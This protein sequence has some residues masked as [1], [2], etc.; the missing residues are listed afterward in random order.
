MYVQWR[1]MA[2]ELEGG[3]R[4]GAVNCG[5]EWML[6]REQGVFG[7]PSLVFYPSADRYAGDRS[8]ADLVRYTLDRIAPTVHKLTGDNLTPL[9]SEWQPYA[10]RSWF[11]D[12]CNGADDDNCLSSMNR[13][14]LAAMLDGLANVAGV[15]CAR[16]S[17]LC[18][19]L[20]RT[21][22]RAYYPIG[23]VDLE[24]EKVGASLSPFVAIVCAGNNEF[25]CKRNLDDNPESIAR[26]GGDISRG[27]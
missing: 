18:K 22:G 25:G 14:K 3:V 19:Q 9:T 8:L 16:E 15:D 12:F 10:A 2:Q 5:D 21:H 20:S 27:A 17:A 6:C 23:S 24:H 4:I 1:K 26:H 13:R 7:Y 11:I